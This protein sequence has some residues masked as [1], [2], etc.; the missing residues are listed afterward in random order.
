MIFQSF[1]ILPAGRLLFVVSS[2]AFLL[3]LQ[4]AFAQ[5]STLDVSTAVNEYR[6]AREKQIITDFVQLL[7]IPNDSANL[8][9]MDRLLA[10]IDAHD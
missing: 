8:A 5:S 9:D 10:P 7:S 4:Q 1:R 2:C 3:P 6:S